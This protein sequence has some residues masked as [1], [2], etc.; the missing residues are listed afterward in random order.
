[1]ITGAFISMF[2]YII[3]GF[4][5]TLPGGTFLPDNFV[6]LLSDLIGYAYAWN[7][8]FPISSLLS[9]L[10][11]L[12]LFLIAELAWRVAKYFLRMVRGN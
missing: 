11:S 2:S 5:L 10:S 8:I 6:L 12:I 4:S 1:M 3:Y 9:V 7:W